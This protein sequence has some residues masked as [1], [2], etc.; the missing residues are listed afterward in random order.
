MGLMN[1]FVVLAVL[2]TCY[3]AAS[4]IEE[5]R[6]GHHRHH[7]TN[8]N[9]IVTNGRVQSLRELCYVKKEI[10]EIT[11]PNCKPKNVTLTSCNGSCLSI[12]RPAV[13]HI[14]KIEHCS[15][16]LPVKTK[17]KQIQFQCD[18]GSGKKPSLEMAY[19]LSCSCADIS[20]SGPWVK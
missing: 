9:Q 19:I 11:R 20:C 5:D 16:C 2:Y 1:L 6:S 10:R 12:Y 13:N 17:K 8:K 14:S 3:I 7:G 4:P 18:V 15:A